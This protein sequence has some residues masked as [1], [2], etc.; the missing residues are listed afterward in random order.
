MTNP[1]EIRLTVNVHASGRHDAAWK[2]LPNPEGLSTNI[3]EFIRIAKISEKGLF[4]ALFLADNF[5]GLTEEAAV[6]PWRALDPA[7][8][9]GALSQST[10]H[11]GLIVTTS[12]IFGHPS[13]VARQI[14]SLDHISHGRAAWNIITSQNPPA[15][16][17]FGYDEGFAHEE[18][19]ARAEEF[20]SIVTALWDSIPREA[21]VAD[22]ARHVYLDESRLRKLDFKGKYYSVRGAL[23]VPETPQG[24]PVIVQAGTSSESRNLGAKWA[25][26]LF[27]GQRT[28]ESAKEFYDDVKARAVKFGRNPEKLLIL[29][30]LFPI[31]G[32]TEA[33][34][35]RRKDELDGRLDLEHLVAE[36]ATRLGIDADDIRLDQDLPYE[37]IAK[38][39]IADNLARRH[40]DQLIAEAQAKGLSARQ[41]VYNN[42][43]G[44][45]RVTLGTPEQIA[46]DVI[47]WVDQG[48]ADGFQLNTDVQTDGLENFVNEVI[49]VLQKRGRFR[50]EYRGKT[51]RENLGVEEY[52][53]PV[54]QPSRA[55]A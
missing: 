43:T 24:R 39:P 44:G 26:A 49:P 9:H 19:Y 10:S 7:I 21:L 42:I 27:T 14:A 51:L 52:S 23:G 22:P 37:K 41:V 36:L 13:L 47:G 28:L 11:I 31:I 34:A 25:D 53:G 17:A 30:G 2:T 45:H 4:D 40:R 55:V 18:R 8:L 48:A 16:G 38:S 1:K 6:R 15:L 35:Q 33:E 5:G 29:P 54:E 3:D 12:T 32:S 20:V 46:D 50:T